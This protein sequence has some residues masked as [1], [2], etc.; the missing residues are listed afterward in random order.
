MKHIE[1]TTDLNIPNM[2][3]IID[4][5][6]KHKY[7]PKLVRFKNKVKIHVKDGFFMLAKYTNYAINV[8]GDILHIKTGN[9]RR[10]EDYSMNHSINKYIHVYLY[11]TRLGYSVKEY[12][13]TLL[14]STFIVNPKNKEI[15][16]HID[17]N[18]FNLDLDNLKWSTYSE[19]TQH[20]H[21]TIKNKK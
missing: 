10:L 14:A 4:T 12:T 18:K 1:Y 9:I 11:S 19:N 15:V 6:S 2:V 8:Y 13:H 17:M 3:E 7:S 16:N 20:Y 5:K 21:D